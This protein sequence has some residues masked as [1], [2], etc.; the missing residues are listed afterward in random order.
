MIAVHTNS[1]TRCKVV[2]DDTHGNGMG[3]VVLRDLETDEEFVIG[4]HEF[5]MEYTQ[6]KE[7]E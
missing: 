5:E 7:D 1:G 6:E 2:E 4:G 3:T